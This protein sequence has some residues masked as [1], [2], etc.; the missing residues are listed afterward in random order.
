[1]ILTEHRSLINYKQLSQRI[2]NTPTMFG[3]YNLY[4]HNLPSLESRCKAA[5]IPVEPFL[6]SGV[7]HVVVLNKANLCPKLLSKIT[8]LGVKVVTARAVNKW[9][10]D[11][12]IVKKQNSSPPKPKPAVPTTSTPVITQRADLVI[13]DEEKIYKPLF[14]VKTDV[15]FYPDYACTGS[16]WAKQMSPGDRV[17]SK[18]SP[19]S[20]IPTTQSRTQ[21]RPPTLTTQRKIF[22]ENC[23]V[24]VTDLDAHLKTLQHRRYAENNKNFAELDEVIGD[25]TLQNL[26]S[27]ST[28]KRRLQV[29]PLRITLQPQQATQQTVIRSCPPLSLGFPF[30]K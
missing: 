19:V 9:L 26:L 15:P 3:N 22:C 12:N 17:R 23:R 20:R 27:S 24:S 14:L 29:P 1:M 30:R 25:L 10:V 4:F 6:C 11:Y 2:N 5:G 21:S 13:E 16:P 7:S 28:K 18:P 8:A